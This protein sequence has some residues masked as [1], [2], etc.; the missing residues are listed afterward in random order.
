MNRNPKLGLIA[1]AAA[2]LAALLV[3]IGALTQRAT[4]P[5]AAEHATVAGW[6]RVIPVEGGTVSIPAPPHAIASFANAIDEMLFDLVGT[7]RVAL[8]TDLSA[9]PRYGFASD[10]AAAFPPE[11]RID[12]SYGAAERI[13]SLHPDLV[14]TTP[15]TD[16]STLSQIERQG[17]PVLR[18]DGFESIAEIEASLRLLGQAT[19]EEARSEAM[20][21]EMETGLARVARAV[22]GRPAAPVLIASYAGADLWTA[23]TGTIVDEII[24]RAGGENVAATRAGI[25]G[26]EPLTME[27]MLAIQPRHL[28]VSS[29]IA[30]V[31]QVRRSIADRPGA[32]QVPA[33]AEGR[34]D[35]VPSRVTGVGS[36]YVVQAIEEV[37]RLLHPDAFG[38]AG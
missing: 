30:D 14:V 31:D 19:G 25:R 22:A 12:Y 37:A 29:P 28:I 4:P 36:Q 20:A 11:R 8:I 15:W 26:H 16:A 18:L 24:R 34:V 6:P 2:A 38:D 23:G 17:I 5:K 21:R 1:S 27:R 33:V 3:G 32:A 35:V 10:R 13:V 9:D 7:R